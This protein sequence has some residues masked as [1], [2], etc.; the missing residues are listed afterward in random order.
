VTVKVQSVAEHNEDL[1]QGKKMTAA[2][3]PLRLAKLLRGVDV[4]MDAKKSVAH[5]D[6]EILEIA[7]DSRRVKP[8]TLFVAIRGEKTDGNKFVTDAVARGAIAVASEQPP[9]AG[10][11][12][13]FPW[14]QVADARKALAIMAA[15][16]FGRPAE[17]LKLIG[18]T[19]T[20][21]K[22]TTS[23][24]VD[25][26]L[27][28]AGCKAAL[29]GT[30]GH[31]L[32]S[33]TRPASHTTPE[34][35][36][37]HEFLDDVVLAGGTH[38]VLEAS[39]HAL[40]MDR[41]WGCP[42]AVTIFTN[43]TR[44]HLDYHKTLEE[45]FAVK[46]RLFQGTGAPPPGTSVINRDDEYGKQLAG[47]AVRTLTYGLESG[48]DITTRKPSLSFSG[49]DCTVETPIG[50]IEIHSKLVGRTN[51]Y[52]ILAAIGAGVALGLPREVIAAGIA[53]LT[54][55]PGRFERIDMGQPFLVVVDYA[56]TDDALR[57]LL[58][59]ARELNPEGRIITLFGC[60]GDRDRTKRPLMGEAAGRAS[61]VVVLTSDN[62]RSEDPLLII[63]DVI[64]G[65]QRT[66]AKCLVEPDRQRAIEIAL[67]QA[68]PGD[69]VLLAGKGHETQQILRDR[70][71]AFD[72]REVAR[73]IL[74]KGGYGGD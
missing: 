14:I 16:Y 29:L 73:S 35:L 37:L 66:P 9:P 68:R 27:R 39:S 69:I 64:V 5:G 42:F 41:L 26:I 59:T 19:G 44:D 33:E 22:T 30:T 72:D 57:N 61:D 50:K 4:K 34:S 65:L 71:V 7:Y 51:V 13:G 56:H 24:L 53:Q 1:L 15:N 70:T 11:P 49:I 23:Y 46:R 47:L 2:R 52:N 31:R 63:N 48:A 12:K 20:N 6:M 3:A 25:S 10:L 74:R 45:Y 54:A 58:A 17:V 67:D 28:A 8:G 36:E 18:V 60:G 62:P 40:A 32:V 43:L 55:V 21:G 38:A